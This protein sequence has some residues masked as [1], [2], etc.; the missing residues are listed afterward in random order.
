MLNN[1]GE[2]LLLLE[3]HAQARQCFMEALQTAEEMEMPA[4]TLDGLL[5]IAALE[6]NA[7]A[8]EAALGLALTVLRQ[9]VAS[10]QT[11]ERA[12]RLGAELAASSHLSPQ[13]TEAAM[14][15]P[16]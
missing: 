5:G 13:Q 6:A 15:R 8:A 12:E 9:P 16:A 7:G 1:R 4:V 14:A 11:H 3:Q 10:Q 2:A